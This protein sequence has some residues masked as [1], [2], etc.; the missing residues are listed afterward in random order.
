KV[1]GVGV[2]GVTKQEEL[3][4]RHG[5]DEAQRDG[6]APNLDPFLAQQSEQPFDGDHPRNAPCCTAS[7]WMKTSS[8][9]GSTSC[10]D[11]AALRM[12]PMLLSSA[13]RSVPATRTARPN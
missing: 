1:L 5:D 4:H 3:H 8:R 10:Q 2:D 11:S 6:V 12:V 9:R 13:E 7:M